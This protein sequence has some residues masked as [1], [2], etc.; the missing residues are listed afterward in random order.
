MPFS[1]A[2]YLVGIDV[3]ANVSAYLLVPIHEID[4]FDSLF[5]DVVPYVGDHL[6][7]ARSR[8]IFR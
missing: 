3:D 5:E 8:E 4:P 2:L 6:A 1:R 7:D